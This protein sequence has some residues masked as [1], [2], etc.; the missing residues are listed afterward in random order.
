[1]TRE[2][3]KIPESYKRVFVVVIHLLFWIL[4][5]GLIYT[6]LKKI[7]QDEQVARRITVINL[8][9]VAS[10]A[11]VY[12]IVLIP[13][14][15]D[16]KKYKMFVFWFVLMLLISTIYRYILVSWT[17]N[18]Y[19]EGSGGSIDGELFAQFL[20]GGF[21][22]MMIA[23][24][25]RII[26]VYFK[27]KNL[28]T[29][30]SEYKLEAE[31]KFLKAQV[32]PHFLFN[33]L[34]N[35]YSLSF[36]NSTK[37]PEMI[38]KLSDMMSFMLYDCKAETVPLT[39]EIEYLYNYISLQQLKKEGE[40]NITLQVDGDATGLRIPPML[41]I[42][43]FENA[44]KHGNIQDT[45]K[46]YIRSIFS[47][48]NGQLTFTIKN[49]IAPFKTHYEKG[50]IGLENVRKRLA[51]LYPDKHTFEISENEDH[52]EIIMTLNNLKPIAHV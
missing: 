48:V 38:L 15:W 49:S 23:T 29:Q 1:M 47:I 20:I 17:V 42:P 39:N 26:N 28:E 45:K 3:M 10:I 41:F 33:A 32:N 21:F 14:Y 24:P 43:F 9:G 19:G 34:N 37:A 13:R 7:A 8:S 12:L 51:L 40:Q 36:V 50:G 46:G 5:T 35:I 22:I 2:K 44:F 52:F 4:Y 30:L 16:Q 6:I 27:K 18:I 11:Y 31:L 25:L